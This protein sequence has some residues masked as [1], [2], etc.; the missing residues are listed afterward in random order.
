MSPVAVDSWSTLTVNGTIIADKDTYLL[1][2]SKK[3]AQ[4]V[5]ANT[6]A[7]GCGYMTTRNVTFKEDIKKLESMENPEE[8]V[9]SVRTLF[10][11]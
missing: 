11:L 3:Y 4:L 9:E 8:Y 1:L 5:W 10:N 6:E 7:V 2:G